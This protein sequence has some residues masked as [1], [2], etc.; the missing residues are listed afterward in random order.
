[1]ELHEML[2]GQS[3]LQ[4]IATCCCIDISDLNTWPSCFNRDTNVTPP[5]M[6]ESQALYNKNSLQ[7]NLTLFF[8]ILLHFLRDTL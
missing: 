5:I 3:F 6:T 4:H 2:L 8:V 7:Q 1:M